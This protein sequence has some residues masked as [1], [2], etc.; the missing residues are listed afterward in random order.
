MNPKILVNATLA[1]ICLVLTFTIHWLFIIP[2]LILV[3]I[4]NKIL[5]S[6][7]K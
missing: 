1:L 3:W 7:N 4:N 2:T 6:K 5:F